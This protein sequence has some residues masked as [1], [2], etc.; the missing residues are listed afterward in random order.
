M[1]RKITK[2]KAKRG[3]VEAISI[4]YVLINENTEDGDISCSLTSKN[5][6]L[7]SFYAALDTLMGT[8]IESIGLNPDIWEDEGVIIGLSVK[9]EEDGF[10]ITITGKCEIEGRYS[11]PTTPYIMINDSSSDEYGFIKNVM[12][13]A[14]KY[15]D[16]ER[17]TP[18]QL[19]M[20]DANVESETVEGTEES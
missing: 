18:K 4:A 2:I 19:S 6:A 17:K 13:E 3:D 8:L 11:C 16:G 7:T 12:D 10:G 5:E 9:H 20:F 14:I 15:L 1:E